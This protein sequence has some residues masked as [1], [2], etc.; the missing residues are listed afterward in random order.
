MGP[1]EMRRH[2]LVGD[3]PARTW[4]LGRNDIKDPKQPIFVR[5]ADHISVPM[6]LEIADRQETDFPGPVSFSI[7]R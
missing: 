5:C 2:R 6:K 1:T 4:L 3:Q 7:A